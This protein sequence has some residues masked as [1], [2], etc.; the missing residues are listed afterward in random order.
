[1]SMMMRRGAPGQ[2]QRQEHGGLDLAADPRFP[3]AA[4]VG[5]SPVPIV[6]LSARLEGLGEQRF[7]GYLQLGQPARVGGGS[8]IVLFHD[9]NP[10]HARAGAVDGAAALLQILTPNGVAESPVA[11]HALTREASLA[12]AATF[13]APQLIQPMGG[14]SGEVALLLR[15]LTAVRHSGVVQVASYSA[16]LAAPVWARILIYDGK[17]LGVYSGANRQLKASLADVGGGPGRVVATVSALR[18]ARAAGSPAAARAGRDR[19]GAR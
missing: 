17:I 13:H 15:D 8:G 10:I 3:E 5:S 11:A 6:E 12:L 4:G 2:G 1:M 19:P 9:G 16:S 14:D 7:N 18:D